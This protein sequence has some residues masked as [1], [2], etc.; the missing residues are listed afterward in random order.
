M[1]HVINPPA[2]AGE[3]IAGAVLDHAP[4][5]S[6]LAFACIMAALLAARSGRR[7]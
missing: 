5:L 6:F 1:K 7:R 2:A 4:A 3:A